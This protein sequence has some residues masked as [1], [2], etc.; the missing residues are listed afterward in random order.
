MY[1]VQSPYSAL[2]EGKHYAFATELNSDI[3][4]AESPDAI[5]PA[6]ERGATIARYTENN[7][8]AG[9]AVDAG[10]YRTVVYGFPIETV[11]DPAQRADIIGS[12]LNFF[13]KQ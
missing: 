3:Y 10:N 8:P 2:R 6:D 12:A 1:T 4:A 9:I 13:K 7:I 11:T 5:K